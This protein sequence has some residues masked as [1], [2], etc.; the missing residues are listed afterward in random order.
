MDS[1]NPYPLKIFGNPNGLNTNLFKDIV[2]LLDTEPGRVCYKEFAN[3]ECLGHHDE[4]IRDCDVYYFFQP[5]YGGKEIL[6]FD[7][8][9]AETMVFSLKQGD[10]NRITVII[11]CLPYAR[12]DKSSNYR[13]S[14]LVQKI[15]MRL[16]M[17]GANRLVTMKLHN[18]SSYN[19]HPATIPI[20]NVDTKNLLLKHTREKGFD[21]SKFK[22][23]A[24]DAGA[25]P[26]CRKIAEELGIP[27]SI[28][29]INK[30]RDP[31][32]S[33]NAE[34]M[35]VI[36]DPSGYHCIIP[37]DIADTCGTA[38]KASFALK[39][40]GAQD[41]YFY[42]VHPILSGKALEN[43]KEADFKAVWFTDTCDLYWKK[44]EISNIEIIPSGKLITKV[45]KNLHNGDSITDL[46][47]NG[48]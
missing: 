4:S 43:L 27:N 16:Q 32:S 40:K 11:P 23:V 3:G 5:R 22:I 25:A 6:S 24:P 48:D 46:T 17:A 1:K 7:L 26:D 36:G 47:K 9:L 42:S 45:I 30:Y 33:N 39:Q 8:D 37:D 2:S 28:V 34:V 13:E 38:K 20:V 18:T 41:V 10:P 31:K 44:E 21:L 19:A 35:E 14:V 29:I 12:Q 15:P